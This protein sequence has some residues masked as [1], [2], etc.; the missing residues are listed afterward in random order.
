MDDRD[1]ARRT[2]RDHI[3]QAAT[4]TVTG[5]D[6]DEM[7]VLPEGETFRIDR[8][9]ALAGAVG[10]MALSVAGRAGVVSAQTATAEA[11]PAADP[12]ADPEAAGSSAADEVIDG[13]PVGSAGTLTVYSGRSEE[14]VGPLVP[15]LEAATGVDL[16]VRYGNTAELAVQILDEGDNSPA[17]LYIAQDA[18]ALGQLANEGRLAPLPENV[19]ALVD[20][21]YRSPDGLWVGV[22]GRARVA[23]YNTDQ[24]AE[25]D[26]PASVLDLTD[27]RW[28]G[29]V[30]WAPENG[31]FQAFITALRVLRGEDIAREWLEGMRANET[32]T[33]EN[34]GS[35]LRAVASGEIGVG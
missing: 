7:A 3:R 19:L 33:F 21:R 30:G 16:E 18:G 22:S 25:A 4:E 32:V 2:A 13:T 35:I 11:D 34:N 14:L 8:R 12:E 29:L 17:G 28:R 9:M 24:L 15:R 10:A 6:G 26:L 5:N 20:P 27:E 23:A 31:S 1:H